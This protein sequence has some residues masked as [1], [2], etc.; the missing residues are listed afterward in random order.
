MYVYCIICLFKMFAWDRCAAGVKEN[1]HCLFQS[2]LSP[3]IEEQY[4]N[5]L[6]E[7]TDLAIWPSVHPQS[8]QL[9]T[10]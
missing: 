6:Y 2:L 3:D 9:W 1:T 8:L 4:L 7:P 10:G 5:P